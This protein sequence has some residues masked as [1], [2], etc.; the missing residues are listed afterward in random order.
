L[1]DQ[2]YQAMISDAIGREEVRELFYRKF[3]LPFSAFATYINIRNRVAE[4]WK[5]HREES[6]EW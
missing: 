5:V 1:G 2:L 3:D 6:E 4:V